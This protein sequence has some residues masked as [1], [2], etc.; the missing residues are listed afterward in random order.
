MTTPLPHGLTDEEHE[1]L[2][3]MIHR[4]K[5]EANEAGMTRA[6]TSRRA[7]FAGVQFGA[8]MITRRPMNKNDISPEDIELAW[9]LWS[10]KDT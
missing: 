1:A 8:S 7:F 10:K 5:V 6:E 4:G 2:G 9:R 3:A